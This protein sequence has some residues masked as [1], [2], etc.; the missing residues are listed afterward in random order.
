MTT[1]RLQAGRCA[2]EPECPRCRLNGGSLVSHANQGFEVGVANCDADFCL[3]SADVFVLVRKLAQIFESTHQTINGIHD[4]EQ[5]VVIAWMMHFDGSSFYFI[6]GETDDRAQYI[7][8]DLWSIGGDF[9]HRAVQ[10]RNLSLRWIFGAP[11]ERLGKYFYVPQ[12]AKEVGITA[13]IG[14]R[15]DWQW[16][17]EVCDPERERLPSNENGVIGNPEALEQITFGDDSISRIR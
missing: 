12:H 13:D 7:N 9:S 10:R 4:L 15:A 16:Q 1:K 17:I 8:Q 6:C 2:G 5:H 14:A 3:P 11:T